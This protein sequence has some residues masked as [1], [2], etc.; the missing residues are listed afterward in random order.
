LKNQPESKDFSC[1]V[2]QMIKRIPAGKVSTYGQIAFLAGHPG[3]TRRVVWILHSCSDKDNL[4]WHR[5]INA[6]GTISLKPGSGYEKQ[7]SLLEAEGV[8]F[9]RSGRTDLDRFLWN[10]ESGSFH[11]FE[12]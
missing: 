8:V 10:P 4:P 1:R 11:F 6:R 5:V 7:K 3:L 2:K 12:T 9:N